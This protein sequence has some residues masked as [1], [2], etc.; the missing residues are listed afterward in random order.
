MTLKTHNAAFS[1]IHSNTLRSHT[2][3][4]RH[5]P[6]SKTRTLVIVRELK[7][8]ICFEYLLSSGFLG[9][10]CCKLTVVQFVMQTETALGV[11][12]LADQWLF[13]F[14]E[15]GDTLAY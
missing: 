9:C 3:E 4:G 12:E 6:L 10:R 11:A 2:Q 7:F 13:T 8:N 1:H 14:A 5:T 15:G